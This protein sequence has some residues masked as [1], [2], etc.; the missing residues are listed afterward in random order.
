MDFLNFLAQYRTPAG[1]VFFQGVTYLA[2]EVFVIAVI[3]WLFWCSDKKL[4]YTLGFTYFFSGL[5]V[6]GLK[7][8]FRIPRPWLLDSDFKPVQSAVADATGYSFPSGHTQSITALFGILTAHSKKFYYKMIFGLIIFLVGFSRMYLGCH[9]LKDVGTSWLLTLVV[10]LVTYI[11]FY[12]KDIYIG[13]EIFFSIGMIL[14]CLIL[15]AYSL[16][17]YTSETISLSYTED[18]IKA[19]GAGVAFALGFYIE[20]RCINFQ[21]PSGMKKKLIRTAIGL[22]VAIAIQTGLKPVMGTSLFASFF[23][24]FLVV[25]WILVL[26]PLLFTRRKQCSSAK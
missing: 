18:C 22:L 8:T 25:F 7:I 3:C 5:L 12:Q 13:R 23:R 10:L 14:A 16:F 26:Y 6:Q 19:C 9:T 21:P 17:L 1:D 24:Y 15:F 20:N 11:L 2:Q 4:A